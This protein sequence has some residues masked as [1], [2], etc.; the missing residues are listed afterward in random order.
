MLKDALDQKPE[1]AKKYINE[2][3]S[4]LFE[5]WKY[6]CSDIHFNLT[7]NTGVTK[8]DS[9]TFVDLG[10]LCFDKSELSQYIENQQ[11]LD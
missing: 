5:L 10:E 3:I 6:G 2:Y 1:N 9:V 8:N 11:W 4:L 7:L